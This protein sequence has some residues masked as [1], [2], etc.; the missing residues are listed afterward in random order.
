MIAVFN[1]HWRDAEVRFTCKALLSFV[2][3]VEPAIGQTSIKLQANAPQYNFQVLAGSERQ[4]SVSMTGG[5]TKTVDW[6]IAR[7]TGGATAALDRG[8]NSIGTVKVTIGQLS[9][10]C[11]IAGQLGSYTVSSPVTVTVRAQSTEDRSQTAYFLFNVCANSTRAAIAPAYQQAYKSQ[12]VELQSYIIGNTNEA[13]RWSI[14]SGPSSG[15]GALKEFDKRDALFSATVPGRYTLIFTSAADPSVDASAVVYVS[16]S[17]IPGYG[18]AT[19]NLAQSTECYPDPMLKGKLYEVGPGL[20]YPSLRSVPFDQLVP[21][22]I[23]RVHNTD[24]TGRNPTTYHE[25]V[26]ITKGG[27]PG[28]PILFCGVP[29]A[30]GTLPV[31]DAAGSTSDPVNRNAT[32]EYGAISVWGR[33][34]Y[35]GKYADGSAGPD[36]VV[37]S[38]FEVRNANGVHNFVSSEDRTVRKFNDFASCINIRSGIYVLT[39]GNDLHDCGNG[40]FIANNSA[41]GFSQVTQFH[42]IRGNRFHENGIAG[43]AGKHHLYTNAWYSVVEGNR[44]EELRGI[45][46]GNAI[47]DRGLEIIHRYNFVH[48]Q[49]AGYLVGIES[50]TDSQPYVAFEAY[51]GAP[52]KHKCENPYCD[53]DDAVPADHIA[54]YQEGLEKS[55]MYGNIYSGRSVSLANLKLADSGG[56]YGYNFANQ[57]EMADHLGITYFYNNTVDQPGLAVFGTLSGT[58]NGSEPL[59]QF[60][61]PRVLAANNIFYKARTGSIS[62]FSFARN[63]SFIGIWHTNLMNK[64]TFTINRPILGEK[65]TDLASVHG[66]DSYTDAFQYPLDIPIDAHQDGIT[67]SEFLSTPCTNLQPYNSVTFAPVEEGGAVNAGTLVA[68]PMIGLMPVRFQYDVEK[69]FLQVRE[70]SETIGAVESGNKPELVSM[71]VS[72]ESKLMLMTLRSPYYTPRPIHLVCH[73]S[74]GLTTDCGPQA[75]F[76]ASNEQLQFHANNAFTPELPSGAHGAGTVTATLGKIAAKPVSFEINEPDARQE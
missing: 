64:D 8:L 38:G 72:P 34:V 24:V 13:G 1:R 11:T 71:E 50:E 60:M 23:V 5:K 40:L 55:F 4:I 45:G 75:A 2:L 30:T 58:N 70:K 9:G 65:S 22:S 47:K 26:R 35:N 62:I 52:G 42:T 3:I 57:S 48:T 41:A 63:A 44:F 73:Y 17:G 67:D 69:A 33:N 37:V 49:N 25:T 27:H 66:W 16:P 36:Y 54:A 51:L 14:A 29:D 10:K 18:L 31:I 12:L 7:T 56:G 59:Q 53:Y 32:Q 76:K 39:A 74:D 21:G 43:D 20:K 6:E 61:K 46:G 68:D 28:Q 15:D 19:K